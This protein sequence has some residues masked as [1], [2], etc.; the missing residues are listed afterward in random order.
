V[1]AD[2]ISRPM[3]SKT[4]VRKGGQLYLLVLPD[5]VEA[6]TLTRRR[7]GPLRVPVVDNAILL[8]VPGLLAFS[9]QGAD[10]R[11]Q[12]RRATI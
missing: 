6:V 2:A 11:T 1:A 9:W 8:Q 10:G 3:W 4:K 7:G 5:G 12:T